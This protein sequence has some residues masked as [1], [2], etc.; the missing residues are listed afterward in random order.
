MPDKKARVICFGEVPAHS[1]PRSGLG[2]QGGFYTWWKRKPQ[3]LGQGTTCWGQRKDGGHEVRAGRTFSV[4]L[5]YRDHKTSV[6]ERGHM[7]NFIGS[8][9]F[10]MHSTS[11]TD[12]I[13]TCEA[14][15]QKNFQ[16]TWVPLANHVNILIVILKTSSLCCHDVSKRY[17]WSLVPVHPSWYPVLTY[18]GFS[19]H[20][21]GRRRNPEAGN[22]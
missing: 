5:S 22:D 9:R 15:R 18:T 21:T 11:K 13:G 4:M 12:E 3:G 8:K 16:L 17:I 20:T 19:V 2:R 10:W 7:L 1:V 6:T 14:R